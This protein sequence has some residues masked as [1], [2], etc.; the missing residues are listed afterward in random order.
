M[1]L[2]AHLNCISSNQ[3]KIVGLSLLNGLLFG[4]NQDRSQE[5]P[6]VL[7][8]IVDDLRPELAC[9]GQKIRTP[10]IDKLA[11]NGIMFNRAYCNIPVSGASRASLLTG[12]RPTKNR[13]LKYDTSAEKDNPNAITLPAY[14]K[15]NGYYTIARS[16]VFGF[17]DDSENSWNE[18]WSP[19]DTAFFWRDYALPENHL[20]DS[21][22]G[23]KLGSYPYECADVNDTTYFDGKA[24]NRAI[25]D[26][27]KLKKNGKPFF[28]A[29][30]LRKPHLPFNSP[31]KYWDYYDRKQF[32]LPSN[33]TIGKTTIPGSAFHNSAELRQ[34]YGVPEKGQVSDSMAIT[35][36][37]GYYAAVSYADNLIGKLLV[38][39]DNQN[40]SKNTIVVLLGD[41]GWSLGEHGLWCKHS[42]FNTSLHTPLIVRAPNVRGG[43]KTN[44]ITEYLD[45]YPT[46]CEMLKLDPPPYLEGKSFVPVL[47]D[48]ET[49]VKD[50]AVCKWMNG[51]TLIYD[52]Y[53]Y[54]EWNNS[55]D[56]VYSRMLFDHSFDPDENNNI[57]NDPEK[58]ELVKELS[59][60]LIKNR[61]ADFLS[62]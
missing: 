21:L 8:I 3:V 35:L 25:N 12:T 37:H 1:K 41:N 55:T 31:K 57:V 30:G 26:L 59:S 60:K 62:N 16:K 22:R 45:I 13:F 34:Y 5:K 23:F 29:V 27:Q 40:L 38:E 28:L 2:R 17:P 53:F 42:N 32:R 20:R 58:T 52:K 24:V 44:A 47:K 14:L 7:F 56:S 6:N 4:C 36:I 39:L 10:N 43:K 46:L 51:T 33:F 9:Y 11:E 50:F 18:L 49:S 19:I 54:T 15:N 61:G 48:P